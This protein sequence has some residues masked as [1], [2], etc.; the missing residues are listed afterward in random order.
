MKCGMIFLPCG[1]HSVMDDVFGG[2]RTGTEAIEWKGYWKELELYEERLREDPFNASMVPKVS[3]NCL[4]LVLNI[5]IS[6]CLQTPDSTSNNNLQ[7]D[8]MNIDTPVCS[9]Q[10]ATSQG[11]AQALQTGPAKRMIEHNNQCINGNQFLCQ[12]K[13]GGMK[14]D[15]LCAKLAI[16]RVERKANGNGTCMYFYCIGCDE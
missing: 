5:S 11:V 12:A 4:F 15:K 3:C 14:L 10:P 9:S 13:P 8:S 1:L 2:D 7:A 6:S 16:K